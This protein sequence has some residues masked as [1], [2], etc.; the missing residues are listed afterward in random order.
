MEIEWSSA[1]IVHRNS[2]GSNAV[3]VKTAVI[4]VHTSFSSTVSEFANEFVSGYGRPSMTEIG[5]PSPIIGHLVPGPYRWL[6]SALLSYVGI[7]PLECGA[8]TIGLAWVG[9]RADGREHLYIASDSRVTGGLRWDACPKILPLPRS[10]CALAFAG[11]TATTYPLMIQVAN[12]IAA[13]E[14]ARER[15]L[16]I[17]RVKNHLLRVLTDFVGRM[18][19]KVLPFARADAEFLFAGYSWMSKDFRIWT[20]F[21]DEASKTFISR[22]AVSFHPH[23]AKAAFI[24]DW[25]RRFRGELAKELG[26]FSKPAYLAPFTLLARRLSEVGPEDSIGGPPQLIRISQHM[27]TRPL[28]VRWNG[29]DTLFGRPLFEYENTDYWS[30]DPSTGKFSRPRKFGYRESEVGDNV[31]SNVEI[32]VAVPDNW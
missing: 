24:G 10:D 11:D 31:E 29:E 8:M 1:S 27:N 9:R 30:V 22:E 15:S 23:L 12:A 14:P 18:D 21:F 26:P 28:C 3:A 13:H 4:S 32:S 20:I 19:T 7:P 6:L 16:D 25:A 5:E 2:S 17:G